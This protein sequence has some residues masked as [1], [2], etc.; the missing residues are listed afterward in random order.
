MMY[1]VVKF[2]ELYD[3]EKGPKW[4][5][6]QF[7]V[8]ATG[9]EDATAK[10]TEALRPYGTEFEVIGCNKSKITKVVD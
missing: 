6:D 5:S 8:Y 3:T 10:L 1:Y 7:L 9:I 2:K 4:R